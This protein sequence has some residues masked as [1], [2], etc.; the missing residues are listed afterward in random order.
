LI[1]RVDDYAQA[2]AEA[3]RLPYGLAAYAFSRSARTMNDLA[4]DI[5]A[6]M[7]SINHHGLALPETPF[8]GVKESGYGTEGG[9][10]GIDAYLTPKFVSKRFI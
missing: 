3:N 10:E 9:S 4:R 1:N 2:V 7:L 6:G 8:G 5:E